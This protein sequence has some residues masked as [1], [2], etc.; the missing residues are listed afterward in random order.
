M[1]KI[2]LSL[3]VF[4]FSFWAFGGLNEAKK[5]KSLANMPMCS[6]SMSENGLNTWADAAFFQQL[7][8]VEST[9]SVFESDTAKTYAMPL[10]TQ[11]PKGDVMLCEL[12]RTS[13]P[14]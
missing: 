1:I 9:P 14:L 8:S 3:N 11:T 10:L 13:S 5:A 6:G 4:L 7:K 2:I 12:S